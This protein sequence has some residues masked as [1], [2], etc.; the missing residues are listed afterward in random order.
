MKTI[1]APALCRLLAELPKGKRILAAVIGAPGSGKST[2]AEALVD[3]L[4]SNEPGRAALLPMDGYHYDDMLLQRLGRQERKGAPDTFDVPGLQ[5]LLTRLRSGS[6]EAVAVPLFDRNLEI[7]RAAASLIPPLV[8][9]IVIEGNYLLLRLPPWHTL[10][11]LFD[12]T[13]MIDVP[14]AILR[15]RLTARW[16]SFGL[17][18]AEISRKV[19]QVDLPNGILVQ[20]ESFRPHYVIRTLDA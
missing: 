13:V 10:K 8:D 1:D 15:Q 17:P 2:L 7:A 3:E 6:E 14:E 11:P 4:N 18:P 9:I 19:E 20:R 12:V 5:H 16:Q